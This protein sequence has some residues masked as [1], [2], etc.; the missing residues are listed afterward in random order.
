MRTMT[1]WLRRLSL[2]VLIGILA[3]LAVP[4]AVG[5]APTGHT[6]PFLGV[7]P[8]LEGPRED[9]EGRRRDAEAMEFGL[10]VRTPVR[11]S[12]DGEVVFAGWQSAAT[13]YTP[14]PLGMVVHVRHDD[15]TLSEYGYLNS[16]DVTVGRRVTR[17][18]VIALS[19]MTGETNRPALYFAILVGTTGAGFDGRS[20][21]LRD[22]PGL[23]WD[24][25][26]SIGSG[27]VQEV[28]NLALNRAAWAT[29]EESDGTA[30]RLAVDGDLTTRYSSAHRRQPEALGVELGGRRTITRVVVRWEAA[31]PATWSVLVAT[32]GGNGRLDWR[33]VWRTR[34]GG[35]EATFAAVEALAVLVQSEDHDQQGWAN[36]SIHELEVFGF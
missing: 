4:R 11:A 18:E 33:T 12:N 23:D 29:S 36:M 19:G 24:R 22:M 13:G 7:F 28:R 14:S 10:P 3:G 8:I 26:L 16:P 1:E 34:D 25:S 31:Q 2:L 30:A 32:P 27:R 35:E 20:V 5:A 15:G 9:A 17:G 21:S 6:L